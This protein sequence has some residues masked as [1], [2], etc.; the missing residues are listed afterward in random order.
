MKIKAVLNLTYNIW[1]STSISFTFNNNID[2]N[3]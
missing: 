1:I 3:I 2:L